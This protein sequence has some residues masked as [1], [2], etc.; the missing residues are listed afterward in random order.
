M[1][2]QSPPLSLLDEAGWQMLCSWA[3]KDASANLPSTLL[4]FGCIN[5]CL[6]LFFLSD[7]LH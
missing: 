2:Q 5:V 4:I 6:G 1:E 7:L 3:W